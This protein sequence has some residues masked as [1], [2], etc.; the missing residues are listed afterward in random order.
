MSRSL[1]VGLDGS[2]VCAEA[3]RWAA[4][5][6]SRRC[7]TLKLVQVWDIRPDVHTPLVGRDTEYDRPE[8]SPRA[9]AS[10][11]RDAHPGLEVV[12]G[13]V[14]GDP[15]ETLCDIARKEDLLVL[16]SRGLGAVAGFALG[17]VSLSVVAHASRPVVLVRA[18]MESAGPPGPPPWQDSG[19]VVVGVDLASGHD[20]VLGFAF[21]HAAEHGTSVRVV[22]SWSP[23]PFHGADSTP[24]G[25][26]LTAGVAIAKDEALTEALLPW[27]QKF[28]SVPVT[29]LCRLGRP[30]R[31][32]VDASQDAGL[33]VVGRRRRR[34]RLGAHL[35]SVTHAVL[36]H[37]GS[38]VAVVPHDDV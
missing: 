36:H 24:S 23:P 34:A 16:G 25:R 11:V 15:V 12:T 18:P 10:R 29:A 27:R 14:C 31:D 2:R 30:A 13:Y 4:G 32:L 5:E 7:L 33:V 26:T 20:E 35:G 3:V 1:T 6:A 38:P 22:H 19:P 9:V 17:S 37:C 28:P 8:W 21:A